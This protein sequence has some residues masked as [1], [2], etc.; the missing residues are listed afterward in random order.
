MLRVNSILLFVGRLSSVV[1]TLN[2]TAYKDT[3]SLKENYG[4]SIWDGRIKPVMIWSP[5][6]EDCMWERASAYCASQSSQ[7]RIL[8]QHETLVKGQSWFQREVSL[9]VQTGTKELSSRVLE[10]HRCWWHG[11]KDARG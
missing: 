5:V 6:Y 1:N 11:G 8:P 2:F 7:M 3:N 9:Q 10:W 4:N